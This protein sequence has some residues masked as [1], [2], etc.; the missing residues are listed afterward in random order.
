MNLNPQSGVCLYI[1]LTKRGTCLSNWTE[2][3][4]LEMFFSSACEED[5]APAHP[6]R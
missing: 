1:Y 3:Y 6:R 2:L 5:D 4:L